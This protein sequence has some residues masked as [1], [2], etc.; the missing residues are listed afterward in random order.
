VN[1][2]AR[3]KETL[4]NSESRIEYLSRLA[5]SALEKKLNIVQEQMKIAAKDKNHVAYQLLSIWERQIM[6]ARVL[7]YD[8]H[9]QLEE[10]SEI[11]KAVAEMEAFEKNITNDLD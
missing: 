8:Q 2:A 10:I 6:E 7:K 9:P 4:A 11:E 5:D 1:Y 3:I